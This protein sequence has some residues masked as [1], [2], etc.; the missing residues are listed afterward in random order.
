[1][2]R[3]KDREPLAR[4]CVLDAKCSVHPCGPMD[5]IIVSFTMCS[6]YDAPSA[7]CIVV[8]RTYDYLQSSLDGLRTGLD[9]FVQELPAGEIAAL[10]ASQQ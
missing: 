6:F 3:D 4:H 9:G 5:D 1:M 8:Q 7:A 10:P 2:T